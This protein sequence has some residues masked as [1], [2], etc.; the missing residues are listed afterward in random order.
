MGAA[1]GGQLPLA[2]QLLARAVSVDRRW[3]ELVR[4]VPAWMF[5]L[6]EGTIDELTGG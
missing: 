2:K 3:N 6:S 1:A 5:P 4:R